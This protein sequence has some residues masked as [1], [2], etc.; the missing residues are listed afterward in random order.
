MSWLRY[1]SASR[2]AASPLST[3]TGI[4]TCCRLNTFPKR[5]RS[6]RPKVEGVWQAQAPPGCGPSLLALASGHLW[7]PSSSE[8]LQGLYLVLGARGLHPLVLRLSGW[9]RPSYSQSQLWL[10]KCHERVSRPSQRPVSQVEKLRFIEGSREAQ[11]LLE[12]K[13]LKQITMP[14]STTALLI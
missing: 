3:T 5:R 10:C 1:T 12:A 2:T 4:Q 11:G 9:M 13:D 6:C 8:Q 14:L 7:V